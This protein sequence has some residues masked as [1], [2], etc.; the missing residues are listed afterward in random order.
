METNFRSLISLPSLVGH[1]L[2]FLVEQVFSEVHSSFPIEQV[3]E[4]EL[5]DIV[6]DKVDVCGDIP[7]SLSFNQAVDVENTADPVARAC[8][9]TTEGPT[10]MPPG[11]ASRL[12]HLFLWGYLVTS[13]PDDEACTLL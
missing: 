1:A 5:D 2:I 12:N 11:R 13:K 9:E 10:Q 3:E 6:A 8:D 7:A 4:G